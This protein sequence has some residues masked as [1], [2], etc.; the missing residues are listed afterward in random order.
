MGQ[1]PRIE[2]VVAMAIAHIFLICPHRRMFLFH[3]HGHIAGRVPIGT[4]WKQP[5]HHRKRRQR[6]RRPPRRVISPTPNHYC[7]WLHRN[8]WWRGY[9]LGRGCG[10]IIGHGRR[11]PC[12]RGEM[13]WKRRQGCSGCR[14]SRLALAIANGLSPVRTKKLESGRE[15]E[16]GERK[17][18]MV[19]DEWY[20]PWPCT[21]RCSPTCGCRS[22][23]RFRSLVRGSRGDLDGGQGWCWNTERGLPAASANR[24]TSLRWNILRI[25]E[26]I[27][28]MRLGGQGQAWSEEGGVGHVLRDEDD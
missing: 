6:A 10:Y 17:Y 3:Q 7:G 12:P 19:M 4:W 9:L 22:P 2:E 14:E 28:V 20:P 25:W 27:V 26:R 16:V 8:R 23:Q 13:R 18:V 11:G 24:C 5:S 15:G 1:F 21:G